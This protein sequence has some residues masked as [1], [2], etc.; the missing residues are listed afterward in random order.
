MRATQFVSHL[1][2]RSLNLD[3]ISANL[4]DETWVARIRG[5]WHPRVWSRG[6]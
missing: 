6:L 2:C 4:L 3:L 1:V 5:P